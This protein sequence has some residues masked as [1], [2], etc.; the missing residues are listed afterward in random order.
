MLPFLR[1]NRQVHPSHLLRARN[2]SGE[3]HALC[4][5]YTQLDDYE[6]ADLLGL[7]A[8]HIEQ[9]LGHAKKTKKKKLTY[10]LDTID[11]STAI[12]S[13]V[14]LFA[15]TSV[16]GLLPLLLGESDDLSKRYNCN[17]LLNTRGRLCGAPEFKL[18]QLRSEYVFRD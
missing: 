16:S 5:K 2:F 8:N 9:E 1:E 11:R 13:V 10:K 12:K 6:V 18:Y 7:R 15:E 17:G 14:S 4:Q 3:L